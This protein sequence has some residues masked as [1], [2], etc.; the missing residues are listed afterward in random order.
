VCAAMTSLACAQSAPP[1]ATAQSTPQTTLEV[2][3]QLVREGRI[4]SLSYTILRNDE[5]EEAVTLGIAD[6]ETGTAATNA[7]RYEAASLTKPLIALLVLGE[8]DARR[9]SLDEFVIESVPAPRIRDRE[10][11]AAVTLRQLLSHSS[12]LPNWSGDSRDLD[13]SDELDFEFEPGSGF[14]YSGEGYGLL[15]EFLER[16]RGRSLRELGDELFASLGMSASTLVHTADAEPVARGHFGLSPSREAWQPERAVPAWSLVTTSADYGRFLAHVAT[17]TGLSPALLAESR[18]TQI[19]IE[20]SL[21]RGPHGPDRLGWSLGWGV[22]ERS[23]ERVFFQ[24]GDNGAFRAFA[25]YRAPE[26]EAPSGIAFF[27]NGSR[28]LLDTDALAAPV[29]G[30]VSAARGWFSNA[31]LEALRTIVRR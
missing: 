5:T 26:G 15:G 30:D 21:L 13:R 28:G 12:G 14:E 9:A 22:L 10:R 19:A 1:R 11:Y 17:G 8:V 20:P 3:Q 31:A 2:A 7:T 6:I 23:D 25:A 27:A 18:T 16:K 4:P 29:L 24:W